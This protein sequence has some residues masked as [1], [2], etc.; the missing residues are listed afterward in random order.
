L[1]GGLIVGGLIVGGALVGLLVGA[2]ITG[3]TG[4]YMPSGSDFRDFFFKV[5]FLESFGVSLILLNKLYILSFF[6]EQYNDAYADNGI[7]SPGYK[8][9][10]I[11]IP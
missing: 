3:A 5:V 4:L 7:L 2:L 11:L 8:Y 1:F 10:F 6:I 9:I